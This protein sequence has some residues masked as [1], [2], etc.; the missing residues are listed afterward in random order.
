MTPESES[1]HLQGKSATKGLFHTGIVRPAVSAPV[2]REFLTA[3][4]RRTCKQYCFVLALLFL[5]YFKYRLIVQVRIIIMHLSRMQAICIDAVR[6]DTLAEVGLERI[7]THI[8]QRFQ[9]FL[10][11]FRGFRIGK[12]HDRHT[13]LPHIPLPY[14]AVRPLQEISLFHT[15]IKKYGLLCNIRI[16]PYAALYTLF[17]DTGKH[18][19]RIREYPLIPQQIRPVK[20]LHPETVKVEYLQRDPPF[21]HPIDKVHH[22]FFI[23]TCGKRS[24]QPQAKG[25][26]RRQR[27]LPGQIRIALHHFL[28]IRSVDKKV[29]QGFPG[30]REAHLFH[31]F[32]THFK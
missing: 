17:M 1:R 23:I 19:C 6:R 24:G 7:Y 30:Y 4:R 3:H 26:G 14:A 15:F 16:D 31:G 9:F 10:E 29:I 20:I 2:Y 18:S 27:R 22:R 13:R 8:H 11:P 5:Q 12:V 25:P 21:E 32:G 28:R